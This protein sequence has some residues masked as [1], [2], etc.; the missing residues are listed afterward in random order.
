MATWFNLQLG[1]KNIKYTPLSPQIKEY[2]DCDENGNILKRVSGSITKGHFVNE[3][4]GQ[5]QDKAFKL[6]NGKASAGFT[7]KIKEVPNPSYVE[8]SESEDLLTE[9]EFLVESDNLF[10]ELTEKNQ[11]VRFNGWFGNGYKAYKIYVVPSELYRGFC[12]MKCGRG[13]KSEIIGEIVG[14]L[15][16]YRALKEKLAEI[17]STIQN[18]NKT[19]VDDLIDF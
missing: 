13:L 3:E 1:N 10:N 16:D 7:G 6:I 14:S 18:V 9:K 8:K 17:E 19:K 11:A 15:K 12:I 4:T 2:Q 5:I